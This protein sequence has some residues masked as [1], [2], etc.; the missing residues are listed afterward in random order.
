[1]NKPLVSVV[2]SVYN[3][4]PSYLE[5][6]VKSI[7]DQSYSNFEF[8]LIDDASKENIHA[9]VKEINDPRIR[10]FRNSEN[11]GLTVS[12]NRGIG[13]ASGKYIAR[14]DSDDLSLRDR[15][16]KQ[17][18]YL[19]KNPSVSVLGTRSVTFGYKKRI[20]QLPLEH[21]KIKAAL[22]LNSPLIHP[23]V[24]MRSSLVKKYLYNEQ[25]RTA[26]DYELWSRLIWKTKFANL[27][28]ILLKRRLH[29]NQI[30]VAAT[31]NQQEN[32]QR[33][34]KKMIETMGISVDQPTLHLL[35][36]VTQMDLT[37]EEE[38]QQLLEFSNHLIRKNREINRYAEKPLIQVL[39][40]TLDN[41]NFVYARNNCTWPVKKLYLSA[42]HSK[43]KYY[44]RKYFGGL[45]GIIRSLIK[46][47]D[48]RYLGNQ[49]YGG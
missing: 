32:G 15:F 26:Q 35:E 37:T 45:L 13:Y 7:L 4:K 24:M 28:Q 39:S 17:V 43:N 8:I 47:I 16:Q 11:K 1:M 46:V 38:L 9:L 12:L 33:I 40:K 36:K 44:Y 27:P 22:L 42:G 49:G 48:Q 21:E 31:D 29:K 18:D 30:S 14:M 3:T 23:T 25:F 19:E 10:Y 6:A 2:M 41:A 5:E 34:R 20:D